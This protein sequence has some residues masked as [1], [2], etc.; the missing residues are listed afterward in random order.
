MSTEGNLEY[1][2]QRYIHFSDQELKSGRVGLL[3]NEQSST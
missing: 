1:S 2:Q 3:S